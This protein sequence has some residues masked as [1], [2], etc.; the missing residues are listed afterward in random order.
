VQS[1]RDDPAHPVGKGADPVH[2]DPKA[3]ERCGRLHHAAEESAHQGQENHDAA[4]SLR[5]RKCCNRHVGKCA[6]IEKELES[7]EEDEALLYG[8]L[9]GTEN[10]KVEAC[11]NEDASDNLEGNFDDDI[12]NEEG[13]PGVSLAWAFSN[14]VELPLGDEEGLD[15]VNKFN[16][17]D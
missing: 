12:G 8:T 1:R 2:E 6:G 10:W 4:G 3:R 16:S 9:S 15:L 11:V 17:R 13:F 14:L 5:I 7:E